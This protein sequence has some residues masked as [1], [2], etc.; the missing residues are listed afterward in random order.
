LETGVERDAEEV[1]N[2]LEKHFAEIEAVAE[3]SHL[4]ENAF[5]R[6]TKAKK[7]VAAMVATVA[8]FWLTVRA[9]IE[10]LGLAPQM[11]RAMYDHLI[12]GIYLHLV[13]EKMEDAE[14]RHTLQGKSAGLL[15][16]LRARDGPLSGLNPEEV[17]TVEEVALEC[18]Q[19]FQRSSSCVEGRN[20]QLAL[21]H[22]RLHR[23]SGRKLAALTTVH[24]YFVRREDGTTAAERFFGA[25]PR[26]LFEWVLDRADLPGRPAEKRTQPQRGGL[27]LTGAT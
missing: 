6:I 23:I 14:Q 18:A 15:A 25:Q 12:P 20:G 19:L 10:A 17:A 3:R 16:P 13:S 27:L 8:F 26:D 11:E 2:S 7:V 1:S 21:H 5:K 22:H 24:N 4:S 9:K